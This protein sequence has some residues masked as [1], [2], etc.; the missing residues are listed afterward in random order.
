MDQQKRGWMENKSGSFWDGD[1]QG[2]A[3]IEG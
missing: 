1:R 3:E 2:L